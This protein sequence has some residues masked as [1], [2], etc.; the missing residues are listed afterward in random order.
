[1][2]SNQYNRSVHDEYVTCPNPRCREF[3]APEDSDEFKPRCWK[4]N[5]HL[6]GTPVAYNDELE[7]EIIDIHSNGC[8]L[9]RTEDGFIILIDGVLPPARVLARIT[10]VRDNFAY[11]EELER[12]ELEPDED[13]TEEEAAVEEKPSRPLGSRDN[14]WG[15]D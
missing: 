15:S 9:G 8:G 13:E 2:V 6:N 3:N 12:L 7:L 14:F 10:K 1:M 11:A 5:T 4:C